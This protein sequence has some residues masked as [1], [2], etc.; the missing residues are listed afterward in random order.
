[1]PEIDI[2]E[3]IGEDPD[4]VAHTYHYLNESGLYQS[5]RF[6]TSGGSPEE[7]F[8]DGFHTYGVQWKAGEIIWYVDGV[9]VHTLTDANVSYQLM[10]VIINLAIGGNFNTQPVDDS[11]LP[12]ELLVDYVRVYQE[13]PTE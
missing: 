4:N 11:R 12:A 7:G 1:M 6:D 5:T 9:A 10:Y 2:L 8:G 3:I 13:R